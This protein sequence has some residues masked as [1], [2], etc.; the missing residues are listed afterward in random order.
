MPLEE[1]RAQV[2]GLRKL[3]KKLPQKAKPYA[4][5]IIEQSL[6]IHNEADLERV[7][8]YMDFERRKLEEALRE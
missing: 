4:I 2:R 3:V 5:A 7:R 8:P 1:L 6:W